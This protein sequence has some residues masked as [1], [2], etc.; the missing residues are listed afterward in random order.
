MLL[1]LLRI[2]SYLCAAI[3]LFSLLLSGCREEKGSALLRL[4]DPDDSGIDFV[5]KITPTATM[6]I[7]TLEYIYN[8]GAVAVGDFNN[9]GLSDLFFTGN[10]IPNKLYINKGKLQFEDVSEEA[11]IGG[12]YKWKSGA[13]VADVN[14]DGLLDIYVCATISEDSLLR[15]NM[16]FINQGFSEE[17]VP[18]FIDQAAEYGLTVNSYSSNAAFFDYDNDGDLDLYVLTNS[19]QYG[20]PTS[21][22]TKVNNGTSTNT[23][24]L[25]RNNGDGTFSDIGLDSGIL[26]EG[27]GLG[28]AFF[29]V[30]KDG[31]TDIYV[32]NDYITNDLLY[33]ND[34]Q[35]KFTNDIDRYIK[36]QSKFSMGNDIGDINND[37]HLDIITVDM[38]PETNLR[39]KTVISGAGYITYVNNQRYGFSPQFI[40]NMLQLNNGN[41]TFSEIGQLAGIYQTEW[42]WSPLFADLDN[43]G[44]KDLLIT[45]GFPLDVTDR[46]FLS[47][48]EKVEGLASHEDMLK[49]IPSVKVPNY[50]FKNN[51]DLTFKDVSSEWGMTMPSFSNGAAYADLDNDG[52]LDYVVSNINDP[53]SLYENKLYSNGEQDHTSHYLRIKLEGDK[54]NSSGIGAK[55]TIKY[56][57]SKLQFH[58]HAVSRGYI[59]TVEDVIHFGIGPETMIDT[60]LINWPGG[61]GQIFTDV[62]ADQLLV[63]D[64]RTAKASHQEQKKPNQATVLLTKVNH[65]QS[66]LSYLHEEEDKIDFNIQRTLPHKFSQAGPA[67]AVGDVNGDYLEDVVIG[68]SANNPIQVFIQGKNQTFI[69]NT[70]IA[71]IE[72]DAGV[73]L[74]DYD[75]DN[76]LD[77]YAVSGGY[78]F[79][80]QSEKYQDRLYQNDGKGNFKRTLN[81]LPREVSSGSCVRAVDI[82]HDGDLDLFVGGRIIAG[83]YPFAERSFLL[84]NDNGKFVDVTARMCEDLLTPGIV[85]D[86]I[87]TDTDNDNKPDLLVVGEFMAVTVFRNTGSGFVKLTDTGLESFPGW[88]NAVSGADFDKDGDIDYV[89]GNLGLNNLYHTSPERPL[90]VYAKDFDQNGSIEAVLSCYT[91]AEDGTL[92]EYPVHFWDDLNSQSPKFR[93]QFA[94]FREFASTSTGDFFS[95]GDL[96]GALILKASHM[97]SSFIE[98]LGNHKFRLSPLPAMAQIGPVN[99]ILIDDF[100]LDNNLDVIVTG[101]DY[102]NEPTYGPYDAMTGL[103]LLG[104]GRNGFKEM[105][106]TKSGLFV[107]GDAKALARLHGSDK[108]LYIATQ[109]K[110]SIMVFA[111][112]KDGALWEITPEKNTVAGDFIDENGSTSRIEFYYGSG[113]LSQSSRRVKVPASVKEVILYD[114]G[115]RSKKISRR[116]SEASVAP[117]P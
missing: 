47:F 65:E 26:C 91:K 106:I 41:G 98:N 32:G 55:V 43:D 52:D 82:D 42:S 24:R 64:I 83:K 59:S 22:R 60:V 9:D 46:D 76:D 93:K 5:N 37:G 49:Q 84:L 85:N 108:D 8:G 63:A 48:R 117:A 33:V 34:G 51:G 94:S 92:Q 62:R 21:Y 109:N 16:L 36:H 90:K 114:A 15:S 103:I 104:D 6:N 56:G 44:Y 23:D 96:A 39:R 10:M 19:R 14:S 100:D 18:T 61:K 25:F 12:F 71:K 20:I 68:G 50:I 87:W 107:D 40:R 95:T 66:G 88:F 78:E 112:E 70:S 99:G 101:N 58:E 17:G 67:L 86:A 54:N 45:N 57:G 81:V 116:E 30:N 1:F 29:D 4:V 73:L 28:L 102:G 7:L 3:I 79:E 115:G 2:K 27:Y 97:A 69:L 31:A 35:G 105:S 89:A 53:V 13:A 110:D 80:P 77:L 72:E 38:L 113:Y 111:K 74:F 11:G 75:N